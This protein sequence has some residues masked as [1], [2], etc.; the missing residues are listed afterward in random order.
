M[1]KTVMTFPWT[2]YFVHKN[3]SFLFFSVLIS[4]SFHFLDHTDEIKVAKT[5][6][7]KVLYA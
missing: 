1:C 5:L 7:L 2:S 4:L 6:K 3:H